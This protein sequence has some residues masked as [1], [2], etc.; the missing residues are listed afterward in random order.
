MRYG[1]W[2]LAMLLSTAAVHAQ[3]CNAVLT[4]K[5]VDFHDKSLLDHAEVF[6]EGTNI[7][8]VTDS[9]GVFTIRNICPGRY[10][11]VVQHIGCEPLRKSISIKGNMTQVFYLEHHTE[12]LNEVTITVDQHR[13]PPG[14]KEEKIA[15]ER[16]QL[17]NGEVLGTILEALP[18][19][20]TFNTGNHIAKPVIQGL[21]SNRILIVNHGVRQEGQQWGSEHAP[22]IDPNAGG[23]IAV[24]KGASGLRYGTEAIGGVILIEPRAL[25][26]MPG[27]KGS[28]AVGLQSNGLQGSS[29]LMLEGSHP[30][31]PQLSWRA[32]GSYKRGGNVRSPDY[33]LKNTGVEELNF[34]LNAGLRY[35]R[36]STDVYYSQFNAQVGI[37]AG[38]HLG[39]L[40]DLEN[41]LGSDTPL[42]SSGFSYEIAPPRQNVAHELLR[43]NSYV[44]LKNDHHLHIILARQ[45]NRR[46]EYDPRRGADD[47]ERPAFALNLT[48]YTADVV[49]E[50]A[51]NAQWDMEA[52]V[53]YLR[54]TNTYDGRFFI[55]NYVND[56]VGAFAV[57]NRKWNRLQAELGARWDYQFFDVYYLESSELKNPQHQYSGMSSA[58]GLSYVLNENWKLRLHSGLAWRPPSMAELYSDGLHQGAAAVE[59]G[60]STL[61]EERS[62]N[63]S[64]AVEYNKSHWQLSGSVYAHAFSNFIYLQPVFPPTLTIQGAFPTFAYAQDRANLY[65]AE[66]TVHYEKS[67]WSSSLSASATRA[68]RSTGDFL[69]QIPAD[70]IRW[71]GARQWGNW[72]PSLQA[73]WVGKQWRFP[74]EADYAP[75]PDAYLVL[76]ASV[77]YRAD[78][79]VK[80]ARIR[81]EARNLSNARYRDYMNRYRY[82]ADEMGINFLLTFYVPF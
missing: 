22:E 71:Q 55:P 29:S 54:R 79:L 57:V 3:N 70:R 42:V 73:L 56:G 38:S 62:L 82:F 20:T 10:T 18:G 13:D 4:G 7:G 37:F 49:W 39:S 41:A 69:P 44:D 53:Q 14:Q 45:F 65:G 17:Q 12:I 59:K 9:A 63:Y 24:I 81:L 36:W 66:G 68:R 50:K 26:S 64:F 8:A 48:T 1:Y 60:D 67:G 16:I 52:G 30:F 72:K 76:G 2:I 31:L 61:G 80:D 78:N 5:V 21:H 58:F 15:I 40:T 47:N 74:A 43:V 33:Y 75:P 46:E 19:V 27:V 6:L 51:W 35:N 23:E 11:V 32:Q 28:A 34:S 25:P 77:E